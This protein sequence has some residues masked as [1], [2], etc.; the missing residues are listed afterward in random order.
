MLCG[1]TNRA[2]SYASALKTLS[3]YEIEGLV[4]GVD[5]GSL[6]KSDCVTI[7]DNSARYLGQMNVYIPKLGKH[8]IE[9]FEE[10]N[11]DYRVVKEHNVN[12]STVLSEIARRSYD[13]IIFAGYGGQILSSEHFSFDRQYI[14]CHPGWLPEERGSTTLYYSL[15][16]NRKFS[17]TSFFMTAKI[18]DGKM[19]LRNSYVVPNF[20][21][22]IDIW[23]DNSLRADTLVKTLRILDES[24][25][26]FSK[27]SFEIDS[28][29]YVIHP[30]LK[31]IALLS[32]SEK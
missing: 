5:R 17:V 14:H 10:Y 6:D 19:L 25:T 29:Y 22:D 26:G 21:I 9:L 13:Y 28:E 16:N 1:N 27:K 11:W 31:H 8:I 3:D 7:D 24:V 12:S 2:K 20:D 18:D 30:L 32:L 23:I 4:Y 15:L